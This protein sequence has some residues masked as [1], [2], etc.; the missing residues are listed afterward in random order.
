MFETTWYEAGRRLRGTTIFTLGISVLAAFYIALFPSFQAADIDIDEMIEAWPPA[1]REAFGLETLA[2]VEGFLAVE[3]YNFVW[4]IL[5]GL[6]FAYS[7]AGLI[8]DDVEHDRMD[9]L[10]SLPVSRF[11]LLVEKFASLVVPIVTVNAVVGAA[12]YAGVLAIGE[13]ISPT[14]LAMVH[15][16]SIPYLLACAALGL[17]LSVLVDRADVAKRVAIALVFVLYLLE[18]IATNAD[19][20]EWLQYLSPTHYYSPT[21]ILVHDTYAVADAGLLL[22]VAIGLVVVSGVVF[23]RRDI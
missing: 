2:T 10:L 23:R 18:S 1:L 22:A 9:L 7:A 15:L 17:L 5:L 6:Y 3:L 13:S 19:G 11:R 16:L 12:V 21:P 8:A 20:F 4:L 14:S